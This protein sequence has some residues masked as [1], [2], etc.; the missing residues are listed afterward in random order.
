MDELNRT[1]IIIVR[2]PFA[3]IIGHRHLVSEIS[4]VE[5]VLFHERLPHS[6]AQVRIIFRMTVVTQGTPRKADLRARAGTI[7]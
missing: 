1:A 6:S 4:K 3:A 5:D 2:N 7:L